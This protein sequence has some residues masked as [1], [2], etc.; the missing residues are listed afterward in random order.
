MTREFN[1]HAAFEETADQHVYGVWVGEH[2]FLKAVFTD[3]KDAEDFCNTLPYQ[4]KQVDRI[5]L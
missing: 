5:N 4:D 3:K 1:F 2:G